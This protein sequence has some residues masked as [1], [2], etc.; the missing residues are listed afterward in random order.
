[1]VWFQILIDAAKEFRPGN[2]LG[3]V[4]AVQ[5]DPFISESAVEMSTKTMKK[6]CFDL[7]PSLINS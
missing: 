3:P 4:D 5:G 7:I 6:D 1:M 2:Y